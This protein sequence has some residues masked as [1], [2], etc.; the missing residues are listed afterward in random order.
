MMMWWLISSNESCH[1]L[2]VHTDVLML[3]QFPL[4][5]YMYMQD[6]EDGMELSICVLH[7]LVWKP[8]AQ[9]EYIGLINKS[10]VEWQLAIKSVMLHEHLTQWC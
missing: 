2:Q 8:V 9:A 7:H 1:R 10:K 6:L 4:L 5:V 3:C